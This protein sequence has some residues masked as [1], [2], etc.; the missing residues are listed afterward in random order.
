MP[1]MLILHPGLQG[2]L[3][4]AVSTTTKGTSSGSSFSSGGE[5]KKPRDP[6][7]EI[8][9]LRAR[10][11]QLVRQQRV[12]KRQG[13]QGEPAFGEGGKTERWRLMKKL[14]VRR[15]WMSKERKNCRRLSR[16]GM[17]SC[18]S[19]RECR[20]DLRSCTV[21]QDKKKKCLKDAGMCE[22]ELEKV[23]DETAEREA[24]FQELAQKSRNF[25]M[26]ADDL[27]EE[28]RVLQAGEE[29]RGICASQSNG[30]CFDSLLEHL[31]TL[32]AAHARQQIH[33]LQ[34]E[35][36]RRFDVLG[37]PV[38]M[39][40]REEGKRLKRSKYKEQP[41]AKWV[42]L[43]L[44][45]LS[46]R[47]EMVVVEEDTSNSPRSGPCIRD[48][49][50]T[51]PNSLSDRSNSLRRKGSSEESKQRREVVESRK[52]EKDRGRTQEL[53]KKTAR[54]GILESQK[55]TARVSTRELLKETARARTQEPWKEEHQVERWQV[56]EKRKGSGR[57]QRKRGRRR[58][59]GKSSG[60]GSGGRSARSSSSVFL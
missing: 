54:E 31:F 19:I 45:L 12:E 59:R 56:Q 48:R 28:I 29:R 21:L 39:A 42:P 5:R 18:W 44:I 22:E 51:P 47:M 9:E 17:I 40:G 37:T 27:E 25:Q 14:K 16:N 15:S 7:A 41:V 58:R 49:S 32:G 38:H 6:E 11:D 13:V 26:A 23:R 55:E 3:R 36:R 34:E 4:Q 20:R 30:C 57:R 2:K 60:A 33:A 43:F 8:R 46:S 24:H 10:V 52:E 1:S 50:P 53:L 35:F